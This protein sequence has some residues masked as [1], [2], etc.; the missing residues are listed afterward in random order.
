VIG[1]EVLIRENENEEKREARMKERE[2]EEERGEKKN[3]DTMALTDGKEN[4][5][6]R[7][8]NARDYH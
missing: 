1:R 6:R 2:K 5:G 8:N 3:K 7:R 4:E